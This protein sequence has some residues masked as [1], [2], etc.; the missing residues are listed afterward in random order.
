MQ[1][2]RRDPRV[3]AVRRAVAGEGVH[4][5]AT[6]AAVAHHSVQ[7]CQLRAGVERFTDFVVALPGMT[8]VI[9]M[10]T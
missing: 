7:Y 10:F 5:Y 8:P 3:D 4:I 6:A 1:R 9:I 2:V